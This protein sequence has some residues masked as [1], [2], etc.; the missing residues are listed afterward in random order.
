ML[1]GC[2]LPK[3]SG[4]IAFHTLSDSEEICRNDSISKTWFNGGI[5][6]E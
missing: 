4:T 2:I 5:D 6:D 1:F 3:S